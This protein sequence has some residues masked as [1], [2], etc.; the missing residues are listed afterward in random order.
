[1]CAVLGVFLQFLRFVS[2]HG[3]IYSSHLSLRDW[4]IGCS[5]KTYITIRRELRAKN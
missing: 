2:F 3:Q 5:Y 4:E 1:V